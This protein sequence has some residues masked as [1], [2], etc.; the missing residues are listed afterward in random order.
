M[1][2]KTLLIEPFVDE[3]IAAGAN[4]TFTANLIKKRP[5]KINEDMC[6]DSFLSFYWTVHE[7]NTFSQ[8]VNLSTI[9]DKQTKTER[10]AHYL[11]TGERKSPTVKRPSGPKDSDRGPLHLTT[12]VQHYKND[13][14]TRNFFK[15]HLGANFKF[16][17][18]FHN[19]RRHLLA[20]GE[21]VTYGQ[22]VEAI[23]Y[24]QKCNKAPTQGLSD[25]CEFNRFL[26]KYAQNE[27]LYTIN[28][29]RKAWAKLILYSGPHTYE[30]FKSNIENLP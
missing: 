13:E 27:P 3:G 21:K 18:I 7:L 20:S 8:L 29:A 4:M 17:V 1:Q 16:T 30:H 11:K 12:V 24:I 14:A 23:E 5:P 25:A 22:L 19:H 15:Q 6:P 9:G 28:D 10:I 2:H 26:S